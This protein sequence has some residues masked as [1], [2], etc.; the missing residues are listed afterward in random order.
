MKSIKWL[1]LAL[2]IGLAVPAAMGEAL[3]TKSTSELG[4]GGR[5]NFNSGEGTAF[6]MDLNYAYFVIDRL[7][8]GG[9]FSFADNEFDNFYSLGLSTEYNFG[10]PDSV[11][12]L[13]GTDLVPFLGGYVDYRRASFSGLSDESAAVL[14]GETG[15]KFFLTDTM[16]LAL[17]LVG[18]WASED[19]YVDDEEL[20]D[21][22]LFLDLGMRFYF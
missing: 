13:F 17:S 15:V 3:L 9:R 14:G 21:L 11:K 1:A 4:V 7:S 20:T 18:E 8:I 10:L 12:P 2:A 19:I 22:T 5:L 6:R 16:A